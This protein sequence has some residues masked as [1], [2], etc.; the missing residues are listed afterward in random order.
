MYNINDEVTKALGSKTILPALFNKEYNYKDLISLIHKK[1][2]KNKIEFL[3][4]AIKPLSSVHSEDELDEYIHL[5][6]TWILGL[7]LDNDPQVI[8][9]LRT[10]GLKEETLKWFFSIDELTKEIDELKKLKDITFEPVVITRF[11]ITY[12]IP[13]I[14]KSI[15]KDFANT[16]THN[17]VPKTTRSFIQLSNALERRAYNNRKGQVGKLS[18]IDLE[19]KKHFDTTKEVLKDNSKVR[20]YHKDISQGRA[21]LLKDAMMQCIKNNTLTPR[22][23]RIKLYPLLKVICKGNEMYSR[24]EFFE[25]EALD[26][27]H[28]KKCNGEYD[29]Y[30]DK[31]V[32]AVWRKE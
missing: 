1:N 21:N 20:S 14:I 6:L 23:F 8:D 12:L 11:C 4:S 3:R 7:H 24:V 10:L 22:R 27:L 32:K 16:E 26:D 17:E 25:S 15:E 29:T 30:M 2:K 9:K 5:M 19:L 18:P 28:N 13:K 31:R